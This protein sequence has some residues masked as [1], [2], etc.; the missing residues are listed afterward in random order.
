MTDEQFE[1]L[2]NSAHYAFNSAIEKLS[3]F[4]G[5]ETEDDKQIDEILAEVRKTA[6]RS[7]AL[8]KYAEV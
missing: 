5:A 3:S 2:K 6:L 1:D 7:R 4:A 8:H